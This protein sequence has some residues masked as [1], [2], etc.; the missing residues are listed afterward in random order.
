M[1]DDEDDG[2]PGEA[3]APEGAARGDA[4]RGPGGRVVDL[5][6]LRGADPHRATGDVRA[7]TERFLRE[8]LGPLGEG[9][10]G[11]RVGEVRA[12][13]RRRHLRLVGEGDGGDR[14]DEGDQGGDQ[15][16][17]AAA[18]GGRDGTGPAPRT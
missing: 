16:G 15:G 12:D 14:G 1:P 2:V 18:D 6:C 10:A 3:G 7:A 9:G 13:P 17:D 8:L 5:R 4:P 11:P